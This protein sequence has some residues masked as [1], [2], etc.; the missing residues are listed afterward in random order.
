MATRKAIEPPLVTPKPTAS[1]IPE[2]LELMRKRFQE[3]AL[4]AVNEFDPEAMKAELLKDL[5]ANKREVIAKLLGFDNRWGKWEVDHCNGRMSP[6]T[7][8]I[9][10]TCR[11][12][13]HAWVKEG[14]KEFKDS[15]E[16]AKFRDQL[17][18]KVVQNIKDRI[19]DQLWSVANEAAK[20]A[21]T[22]LYTELMK[23][24]RAHLRE[25]PSNGTD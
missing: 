22:E 15:P 1:S 9:N 10:K 25:V 8:F 4:D 3:V 17:K 23:E 16:F 13:V 14:I 5:N 7:D 11:E 21:S 18:A 12:D 6:I 19:N 2:A 20:T 24:A